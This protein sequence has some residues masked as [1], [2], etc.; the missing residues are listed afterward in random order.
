MNEVDSL[1][2]E[3]IG[4]SSNFVRQGSLRKV[5]SADHKNDNLFGR[6][7]EELHKLYKDIHLEY[8]ILAEYKSVISENI[9]SVYVIPS[10]ENFLEWF[11]VI[12]VKN[13]PYQDG[14]FRFQLI[15][16]PG[17]PKNNISPLVRFQSKMFH[18]AIDPET[19]ELNIRKVFPIWDKSEN[20][21]WQVVKFVVWVFKSVEGSLAYEANKEASQ[22]ILGFCQGA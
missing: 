19:N 3:D 4:E 13:G 12:F 2:I 5:I 6:P 14:I 11:G 9:Q 8:L 21:I 10:R 20:H 18:P 16:D 7:K 15:L 22:L 17:Y 1:Q